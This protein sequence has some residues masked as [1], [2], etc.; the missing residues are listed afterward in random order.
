MPVEVD[1][2][3]ERVGLRVAVVERQR[4]LAE[5][6]DV[7]GLSLLQQDV[8]QA[9]EGLD[10][11][12]VVLQDRVEPGLGLLLPPQLRVAR[13]EHQE[14]LWHRRLLPERR[15]QGLGGGACW[16]WTISSPA[17]CTAVKTASL[18]LG[19]ASGR[20]RVD[21]LPRG[22]RPADV[23]ERG[24]PFDRL[25]VEVGRLRRGRVAARLRHEAIELGLHPARHVP[26]LV[27]DVRLLSG[28][29]DEVE[30]LRPRRLDE[31][32]ARRAQGAERAP[33]VLQARGH[34]LAV[35]LDLVRRLRT[36]HQ[37]EERAAVDPGGGVDAGESE[38]GREDVDEADLRVDP[39]SSQRR[40]RERRR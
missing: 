5:R 12:R 35:G 27:V 24:Q 28:V 33:S 13:S 40:R 30:E 15:L 37:G 2:P 8:G 7:I 21:G 6:D 26:M 31:L 14:G 18:S 29:G 22:R 1:V 39:H 34:R 32:V 16:S 38:H 10:A 19:S 11:L 36:E 4:P 23:P 3:Q 25:L 9:D 20:R 17:R